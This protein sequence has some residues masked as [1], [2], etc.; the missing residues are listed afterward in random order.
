MKDAIKT[1]EKDLWGFKSAVTHHFL[2]IILPLMKNPHIVIVVRSLLYNAQSW[3]VHMRDVFGQKVSL[4][5]ALSNISKSQ[6][7]LM[8]NALTAKCPKM[9]TSYEH[10]RKDPWQETERMADFLGI[11]PEPKKQEILDFVLPNHTT[12]AS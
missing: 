10:I 7:V 5:D 12:I 8:R 3:Q 1:H 9:F 11:N 4:E 2:P 6:D